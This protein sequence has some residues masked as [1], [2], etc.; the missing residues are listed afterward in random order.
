MSTWLTVYEGNVENENGSW[1]LG[2][3]NKSRDKVKG[4]EENTGVSGSQDTENEK[5][6]L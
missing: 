2:E 4:K 6:D 5:E 3:D 1:K